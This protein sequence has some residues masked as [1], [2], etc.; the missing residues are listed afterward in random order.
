M[1]NRLKM[2]IVNAIIGLLD[3]GWSYRRIERE[4]GVRRETVSRYDRSRRESSNPAKAP[5]GSDGDMGAKAANMPPGS[6]PCRSQCDPF[7]DIIQSKLDQGLSA[8][9]VWQDLVA[10]H[11]F[12]GGYDSVKR[13]VRKLGA[14]TPLPF[15]RMET[16]PGQES[17]VDLGTG[18]WV[19][20]NGKKRRPHV[21]RVTL[22]NSRKS[23][24]EAIWRQT[25]ESFIRCVENA[26]RAFGG[27]TKTLVI[28]NLKAAVKNADWFD[29]DLNPKIVEFARHYGVVILPTKPRTPRHK[30]KIESGIKYVKNNALKG[31]VFKSL[32]EQ[33]RYLADW[34]NNVADTRVH[35]TTKKQ[36]RQMFEAERPALQPLPDEPF[37]F[38]HEGRR[39][40]SRDAHV[41]VEKAYYSVPPEYLGREVW[42]RWDSRLVRIFND[43]LEQAAIHG[44]VEPGRLN[45]NRAHIADAKIS[46]V[47]RGAEYLLSRAARI[48][49][50]ASRW[51]MA[52][53]EERGIEGVRVLQGFVGLAKKHP[54]YAINHA[55]SVALRSNLFRLRPLKEL[56]KRTSRQAELEFLEEHEIIRPLSEYQK[57]LTVSFK[58]QHKEMEDN[59]SATGQIAKTASPVRDDI[60]P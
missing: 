42:V 49:E 32:A 31:R 40:V 4:P 37:P 8:K 15:R 52:M 59:E 45:T 46:A 22:S 36:V 26:F 24:S 7:A 58:P 13:Y 51:A 3:Q 34:E 44:R 18:A 60:D 19:I 33:N 16:G 25:T 23:Y 1:A 57:M 48:G 41:E 29:P 11:G 17:Q 9:R 35:G 56:I 21:L 27:S 6:R 43:Q 20:E 2:A 14:S 39:K 55:S 28:D 5:P 54:P 38:F 10:D 30:G 47:E 53:L 50:E 12:P